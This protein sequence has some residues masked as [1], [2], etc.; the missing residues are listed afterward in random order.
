MKHFALKTLNGTE[1]TALH[2]RISVCLVFDPCLF[3]LQSATFPLPSN[4]KHQQ[5]PKKL[6]CINWRIMLLLPANSVIEGF[7][8]G[9]DCVALHWFSII[10]LLIQNMPFCSDGNG[11]ASVFQIRWI[12]VSPRLYHLGGLPL[13]FTVFFERILRG[14]KILSPRPL[15]GGVI[16]CLAP[17]WLNTPSTPCKA[18]THV[19]TPSEPCKANADMVS[20]ILVLIYIMPTSPS[21]RLWVWA[22]FSFAD[23]DSS[24]LLS[25]T[26]PPLSAPRPLFKHFSKLCSGWRLAQSWG[27][28][29]TLTGV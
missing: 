20:T 19:S 2:C 24:F 14:Q 13:V 26:P 25:P 11:Q 3:K 17:K 21:P 29:Y 10:G 27:Y 18:D 4:W 8:E 23:R 12:V 16:H 1:R 9:K 7:S 6:N 22:S 28:S 5:P 15:C